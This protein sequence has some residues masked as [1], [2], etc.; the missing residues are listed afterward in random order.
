VQVQHS[1]LRADCR[2]SLQARARGAVPSGAD[3]QQATKSRCRTVL[4]RSARSPNYR[5][6][7][8]S[9]LTRS[10]ENR[11]RRKQKRPFS[12]NCGSQTYPGSLAI[13]CVRENSQNLWKTLGNARPFRSKIKFKYQKGSAICYVQVC[14][15]RLSVPGKHKDL[16]GQDDGL[17]SQ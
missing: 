8:L 2:R 17:N 4:Q 14:C 9:R 12:F 7:G 5:L 6:M 15:P 13:H 10:A 3:L 11:H 16:D 1:T